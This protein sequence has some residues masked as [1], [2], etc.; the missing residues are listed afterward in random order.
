[1]IDH[2][3][4]RYFKSMMSNNIIQNFLI[5]TFGV[6]NDQTIFG[7]NLSGTRGK[8]LQNNPYRVVMDYVAVPKDFMKLHKFVF[9]VADVMFVNGAPLLINISH[10]IKFVTVEHIPTHTAEKLSKSTKQVMKI[11][12]RSSM[13]IQTDLMDMKF[14]KP[15]DNLMDCFG[16]IERTI[17]TLKERSICI[18]TT[19]PFK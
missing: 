6:T 15:I 16:E 12:S 17:C 11:Y 10:G 7:T 13:I 1:M 2:P 14:D 9:L 19:M 3:P 18:V 4:K 5:A 8:T